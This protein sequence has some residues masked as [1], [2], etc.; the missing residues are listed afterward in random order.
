MKLR[1]GVGDGVLCESA[2]VWKRRCS[3]NKT[4]KIF[5]VKIERLYT[6]TAVCYCL[7]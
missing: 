2:G 7:S 3:L 4:G 5:K 1:Q 6:V